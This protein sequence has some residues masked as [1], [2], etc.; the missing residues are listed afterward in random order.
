MRYRILLTSV[1]RNNGDNI[2][3][4]YREPDSEGSMV[5]YETEVANELDRKVEELLETYN[6]SEINIVT[7]IDYIVDAVIDVN[8]TYVNK[9]EVST[10]GGSITYT[11]SGTNLY[12]NEEYTWIMSYD[13]EEIEVV[14]T[15]LVRTLASSE[16]V[17]YNSATTVK[18][19]I[20][21]DNYVSEEFT[22]K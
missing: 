7:P 17:K 10:V 20:K 13:D 5:I 4:Y 6:K 3:K 18:A 2:Y 21:K 9:I 22:L 11:M 16:I 19:K 8:E 12:S 1:T 14:N 15:G